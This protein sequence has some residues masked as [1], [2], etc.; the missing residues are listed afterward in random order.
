MDEP[1]E[2]TGAQ[3][4]RLLMAFLPLITIT[5]AYVIHLCNRTDVGLQK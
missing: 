2:E 5:R 1:D 3:A 4:G